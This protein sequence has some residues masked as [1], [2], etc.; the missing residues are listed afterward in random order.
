MAEKNLKA[1]AWRFSQPTC[2][3]KPNSSNL[4]RRWRKPAR[5]PFIA[6]KS[7]E[8]QAVKHDKKTQKVKV[9]MT[10]DDA[11]P[12]DFDAVLLPGGAMN[13]DALRMEKK[14]QAFVK[15][16]DEAGKPI[17]VICHAPVAIDFVRTDERPQDDQLFHHSG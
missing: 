10:L 11:R 1:F 2:L 13:A 12:N 8:I 15:N 4:A 7:G 3:K 9:D 14:A 17:A 5:K 6:P 16:I